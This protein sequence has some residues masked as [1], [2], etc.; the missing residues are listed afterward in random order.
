MPIV[1]TGRVLD[2]LPLAM[3]A[4]GTGPGTTGRIVGSA[5]PVEVDRF[6]ATPGSGFQGSLYKD[7]ATGK[8]TIAFAGTNDPTDLVRSDRVLATSNLLT[9]IGAGAWDPQMTDAIKFTIESFKQIQ[10][11]YIDRKEEPPSIDDLRQMVTVTGHS[12]GGSLAE[13]SAKF[14]G[15]NGANIDGPGV[16][17]STSQAQY[18]ALH[19][20]AQTAF[21][22]MQPN[23]SLGRDQFGA[24]A[25][26]VVG[27]A[28]T[29]L[30][31]IEVQ[32]TPRADAALAA[33]VTA[34]GGVVTGNLPAI[35]A[36][37]GV[38]GASALAHPS[39][40]VLAE[41]EALAG[42]SASGA[43]PSTAYTMLATVQG[44]SPV[45]VGNSSTLNELEISATLRTVVANVKNGLSPTGLELDA[46]PVRI[47]SLSVMARR[48]SETGRIEE[49][50][51]AVDGT[52]STIAGSA[53]VVKY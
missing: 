3:G 2:F 32:R 24:Y 23:Y 30:D 29:H 28:G 41:T 46:A 37:L 53:F 31:G 34:T 14:F 35:L 44:G 26:T 51:T 15:L 22:G 45:W 25:Y 49:I 12:L 48:D 11:E 38:A 52:G 43:L 4:Y 39:G 42:V 13:L 5:A 36:S 50:Y 9:A 1:N 6:K 40:A 19:T 7:P 33:M 8:Y 10:K 47:G 20:E 17:A 16:M 27:V 21:A 18:A